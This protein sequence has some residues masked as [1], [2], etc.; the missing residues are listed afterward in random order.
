KVGAASEVEMKEIKDRVDDA[1][2]ATRAAVEDG[3]VPGGGV[4]LVRSIV[5]LNKVKV[6]GE[7]KIGINILKKALEAPLR[8]IVENAGLEG[9]VVLNEV[10]NSKA[11]AYGFNAKKEKYED[12]I[13]SGVIDPTKVTITALQNAAS[14]AS[15]LLTTEAVVADIPE[16]KGTGAAMPAMDPGMMGGMGMGGM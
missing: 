3:I 7:E 12:L 2:N 6:V 16:E 4:A 11:F 9:A 5:E 14:V 13:K 1:L 10:L 15:M 8:Q